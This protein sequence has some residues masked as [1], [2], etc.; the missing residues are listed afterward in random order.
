MQSLAKTNLK[1]YPILKT[2]TAC[3]LLMV[4]FRFSR[5]WALYEGG[6]HIIIVGEV[7]EFKQTD[8]MHHFSAE[9]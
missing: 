8:L 9:N 3:L 6:D 1:M 4:S 5:K 7:L 2:Q